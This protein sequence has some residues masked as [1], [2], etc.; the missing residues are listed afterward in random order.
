MTALPEGLY[1]DA[2][3]GTIR[4]AQDAVWLTF[5]T[6]EQVARRGDPAEWLEAII[7]TV[8]EALVE[9]CP[10]HVMDVAE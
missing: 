5:A 4:D 7:A 9:P 2:G 1:L 6:P 10:Y 8:C 3:D